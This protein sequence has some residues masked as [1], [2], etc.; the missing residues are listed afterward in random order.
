YGQCRLLL[1]GDLNKNSQRLMLTYQP[2][3][4]LSVDLAKACHHGSEDIELD[5]VKAMQARATVISSGD[6]EDYA[7]PRPVLMGASARYGREAKGL[8]DESL[9]P[10]VYCTELARSVKLA[11]AESLR[12]KQSDE[13]NGFR[14]IPAGEAWIRA[15]ESQAKYRPLGFTPISTDLVYGLVNVRTDGQ[16]ILCATMEEK[17]T[18]F[19]IKVFQAGQEA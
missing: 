9:P 1:T 5:F 10:L 15:E 13:V 4:D 19:D 14:T 7:H 16:H 12:I 17:G 11:Y 2:M 8:N 6:N 18:D 3:T